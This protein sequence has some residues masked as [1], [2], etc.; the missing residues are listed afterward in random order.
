MYGVVNRFIL[1]VRRFVLDEITPDE[2]ADESLVFWRKEL[3]NINK[4]GS[5]PEATIIADL[6]LEADA[7][8]NDPPYNVTADELRESA[9][10]A[11]EQLTALQA[12]RNKSA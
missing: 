8:S 3:N 10:K 5:L 12:E 11:L 9:R 6:C 4:L 1:L 7:L 2:F